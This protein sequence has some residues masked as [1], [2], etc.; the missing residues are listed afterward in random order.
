MS[1]N[2][3]II[4]DRDNTIIIDKAILIKWKS[5]LLNGAKALKRLYRRGF[6]IFLATNQG[7]IALNKFCVNEMHEFHKEN[8]STE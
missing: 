8:S 4:F 7:G 3:A 6:Q 2:H 1:K 5:L